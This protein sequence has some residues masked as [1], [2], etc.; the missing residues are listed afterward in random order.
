LSRRD[1]H[2]SG[3][4]WMLGIVPFNHH[5]GFLLGQFLHMHMLN[6]WEKHLAD[7]WSSLCSILL[8]L[9][10][11]VNSS[12][13]NLPGLLI[14]GSRSGSSGSFFLCYELETLKEVSQGKCRVH[15]VCFPLLYGSSVLKTTDLHIF[16]GFFKLLFQ[17][18]E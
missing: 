5:G 15:L 13:F 18:E 14:S 1:R 11:S 3:P 17:V 7:V 2:Y 12:Y 6:T 4:V 16:S 10:S 8:W 9:H